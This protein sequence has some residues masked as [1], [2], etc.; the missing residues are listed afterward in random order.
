V[1]VIEQSKVL[2]L[3]KVKRMGRQIKK[4][5][6]VYF[7]IFDSLKELKKDL[8]HDALINNSA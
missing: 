6:D 1:Q 3:T 4:F 5:H 2:G 7:D 8:L